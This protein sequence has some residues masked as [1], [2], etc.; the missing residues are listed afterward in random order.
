MSLKV[1][2]MYLFC[3]PPYPL[4]A[5]I[6]ISSPHI[7]SAQKCWINLNICIDLSEIQIM[8]TVCHAIKDNNAETK[9]Y[10]NFQ[11]HRNTAKISVY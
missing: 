5:R 7:W 3:Y 2:H 1:E 8:C 10:I 6:L 4:H 9:A 11:G